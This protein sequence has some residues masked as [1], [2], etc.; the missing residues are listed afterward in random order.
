MN[1]T[2]ASKLLNRGNL[3]KTVTLVSALLL[4]ADY[5]LKSRDQAGLCSSD[6]CRLA[7]EQL[8]IPEIFLIMAGAYFFW[9]LWLIVFFGGRYQRPFLWNLAY[10]SL[11]SALAFDGALL[12]YQIMGLT[13]PCQLCAGVG[14][15]LVIILICMAW[16]RRSWLLLLVGLSLFGSAFAANSLLTFKTQAP[17]LQEAAFGHQLAVKNQDAR[18]FYLFFSLH[19]GHCSTVLKNVGFQPSAWKVDWHL[20]CV[21]TAAQDLQKLAYVLEKVKKNES[22][23][24]KL[25]EV[26][27]MKDIPP[28]PVPDALKQQTE[29]AEAYLVHM[30]YRGIPLLVVL[31]GPGRKTVISG[32]IGI[33][34]YLWEQ[35]LI[36]SWIGG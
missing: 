29:A 12:G 34:K 6:A 20:S 13:T 4:T 30:G 16:S 28:T 24:V 21:D 3:L 14:L 9:L 5:Y 33:A 11:W 10:L 32:G 26:K 15:A 18:Q 7:A 35:G 31:E 25:L 19:C 2:R 22:L 36:R 1:S 17:N 23:F 27:Q 8:R